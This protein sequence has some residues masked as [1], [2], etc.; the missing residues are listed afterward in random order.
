MNKIR[1]EKG[2]RTDTKES[3][4]TIRTCLKNLYSSKLENPEEM[5]K[6]LVIYNLLKFSKDQ[7]RNLNRP[8][9][10]SEIKVVI[11]KKAKGRIDSEQNSALSSKKN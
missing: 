6:F 10:P 1:D 9:D 4:R 2:I 11:V 3:Q 8:I 7:I 5:V